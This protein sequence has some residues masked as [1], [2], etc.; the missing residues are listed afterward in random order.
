MVHTW[1]IQPS[2]SSTC[3][4]IPLYMS[5][6]RVRCQYMEGISVHLSLKTALP[7]AC[8]AKCKA[9]LQPEPSVTSTITL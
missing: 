9:I 1:Y 5:P 8:I 3:N 4:L 6:L 7:T 2:P